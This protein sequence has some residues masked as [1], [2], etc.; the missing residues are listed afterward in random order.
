M[1]SGIP[2]WRVCTS[3]NSSYI[4]GMN[5]LLRKDHVQRIAMNEEVLN[6]EGVVGGDE[7]ALFGAAKE[8]L[9]G[10]AKEVDEGVVFDEETGKEIQM[11]VQIDGD[12]CRIGFLCSNV[13]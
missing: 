12:G 5:R 2:K 7:E 3:L 9:F 13:G 1:A 8:A 6:E 4:I 11:F 10:A